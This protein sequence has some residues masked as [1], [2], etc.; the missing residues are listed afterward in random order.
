MPYNFLITGVSR[1]GKTTVVE[2]VITNLQKHDLTADGVYCPEIRDNCERVGFEL[3]DIM[4]DE[5]KMLA[6]LEQESGPSVGRYRVDVTNVDAVFG[7]TFSRGFD[8]GIAWSWMKLRQWK[9]IATC[10]ER[11]RSGHWMRTCPLWR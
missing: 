10:S 1:S 2:K 3:V 11:R 9:S 7:K 8:E 5:S 6:Q 4:T